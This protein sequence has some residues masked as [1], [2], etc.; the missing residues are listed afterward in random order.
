MSRTPSQ[1]GGTPGP[2]GKPAQSVGKPSQP[3]PHGPARTAA[4]PAAT[5]AAPPH[6]APANASPPAHPTSGPPGLATRRN[7]IIGGSAAGVV[8][9]VALFAWRPW[10]PTPPRLNEDPAV[11]A[12]WA[13]SS[14][15]HRLPFDQQRQYMELIDEKDKRV[16]EAYEQGLLSDQEFRRSLQ[17]GWYGEHLKKM[18]NFFS[19]AP[20]LRA[21]YLDKQVDKKIR[22][23]RSAEP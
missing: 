14:K 23:K 18:D 21:L 11:I 6:A 2:G 3:T 13:A 12:R 7:L 1:P 9:L 19:K 5:G 17:L 16:E 22:K 20:T 8:L 10:A 15:L 4:A